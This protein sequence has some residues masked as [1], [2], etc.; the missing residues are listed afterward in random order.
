MTAYPVARRTREI[1]LRIAVGGSWQRVV[2]TILR[3]ALVQVDIGVA[4]GLPAVFLMG[5]FLQAGLFGVA[6][7]DPL[8]ISVGLALLAGS[9]AIAALLPAGRAAGMDPVSALRI[10]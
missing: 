8:V 1:G 10:E 9:A 4:I 7:Y 2:G 3:S 6:P 5:R